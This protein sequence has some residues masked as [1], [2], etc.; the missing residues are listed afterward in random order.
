MCRPF[1]ESPSLRIHDLAA[2]QTEE[3]QRCWRLCG[4]LGVVLLFLEGL[5]LSAA[6]VLGPGDVPVLH[7]SGLCSGRKEGM[8]AR[9]PCLHWDE[10][11]PVLLAEWVR[12]KCP[13]AARDQT[14]QSAGSEG[15]SHI[16]AVLCV[17]ELS[18]GCRQRGEEDLCTAADAAICTRGSAYEVAQVADP[19]KAQAGPIL[20]GKRLPVRICELPVE[21]QG[22]THD[23]VVSERIRLPEAVRLQL[24]VGMHVLAYA[25]R[26]LRV[27]SCKL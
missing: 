14:G 1:A 23:R 7:Q 8:R 5:P 3:I 11:A 20:P 6:R 13:P 21:E 4:Q 27:L 15:K 26:G 22:L 24:A 2:P 17:D 10:C 9:C 19:D 12:K 25:L 18:P 16:T